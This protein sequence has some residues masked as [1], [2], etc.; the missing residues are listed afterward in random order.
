[1]KRFI[2]QVYSDQHPEDKH[3]KRIIAF[4]NMM[5]KDAYSPNNPTLVDQSLAR[6]MDY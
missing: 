2:W 3:A 5:I 4:I 1:M 6:E